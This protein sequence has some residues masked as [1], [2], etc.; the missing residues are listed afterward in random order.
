MS[1]PKFIIFTGPMFGSKTTRM[2]AAIDRY[3]YQNKNCL[4]FKPK[5]DKRYAAPFI[6]THSGGR[7]PAVC[8]DTGE[9]LLEAVKHC[10]WTVDIIAVDEAFMIPDIAKA[11]I[12]LFQ[13]GHTI[14]ISS[15]Q[16]S[17]NNKVFDEIRD[18]MPWAT[19]I[20]VCP[21]VCPTCGTDAYY[22]HRKVEDIEEIAVGGSELYEPRCWRHHDYFT[23][24]I[25][26]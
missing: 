18:I 26:E 5:M 8:V 16:L 10:S 19:R 2:L 24:T 1:N 25:N 17:A 6:T 4:A 15:I 9:D 21:A 23:R 22:T 7:I 14:I 3:R 11:L 13:A 20:E 12:K